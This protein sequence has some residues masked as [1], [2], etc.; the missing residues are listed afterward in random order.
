MSNN[1]VALI[2]ARGGSKG[3][4]GK[5]IKDLAGH[6]LIAYSIG[7]A[8]MSRRIDRV[9]V[10]TD[11]SEIADIARAYGAEVPFMRPREISQDTSTDLELFC[12]AIQ[13]FKGAGPI[14]G[15]MVHL[16]PTT[17]FR[18]AGDIDRAVDLIRSDNDA[19]SLRSVHELSEPPQKMFRLDG[20]G[21]LEG[22]FPDDPRPEYYNLPRQTFPKAYHPNGYADIIR[23]EY[24]QR[25]NALHGPRMLGFVTDVSVEVDSPEDF[26]YLVYSAGR[27]GSAVLDYLNSNFARKD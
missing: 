10:S 21:Y 16:R 19:T 1:V 24:V 8:R 12:H 5:N 6:P 23:P 18:T 7:A 11:S 13:W 3:V 14:P 2:P 15:L 26:D 25:S 22:F 27:K 4:P 9:I 17:P 20:H